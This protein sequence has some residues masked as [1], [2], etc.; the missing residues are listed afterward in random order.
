MKNAGRGVD[1]VTQIGPMLLSDDAA[2][3]RLLMDTVR[4]GVT[5]NRS[6]RKKPRNSSTG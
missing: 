3:N 4:L 1:R 5:E 2:D 6:T